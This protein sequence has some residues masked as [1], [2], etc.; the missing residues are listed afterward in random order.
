MFFLFFVSGKVWLLPIFFK[1]F[2]FYEWVFADVIFGEGGGGRT[3]FFIPESHLTLSFSF[4]SLFFFV[5]ETD[6]FVRYVL[7]ECKFKWF[8]PGKRISFIN[9]FAFMEYFFRGIR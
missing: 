8:D 4:H 2:G 6:K 5:L 7:L 1:T 9:L 3:S